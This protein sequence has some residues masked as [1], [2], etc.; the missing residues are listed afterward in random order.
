MSRTQR[1]RRGTRRSRSSAVAPM[2]HGSSSWATPPAATGSGPRIQ[3]GTASAMP[4][5]RAGPVPGPGRPVAA[6]RRVLHDPESRRLAGVL[7]VVL[8]T[9]VIGGVSLLTLLIRDPAYQANPLRQDL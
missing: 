5:A 3:P 6:A 9:V 1:L 7:L 2:V 8:P 4:N